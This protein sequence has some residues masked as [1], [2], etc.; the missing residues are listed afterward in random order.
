M[1]EQVLLVDDD[2]NIRRT[3]TMGLEDNGWEVMSCATGEEA[4][5]RFAESAVDVV[6]LDI[7]LPGID[8]FEVCRRIRGQVGAERSGLDALIV[9][10]TARHESDREKLAHE[11]GGDDYIRKPFKPSELSARMSALLQRPNRPTT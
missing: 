2:P 7:G 3:L 5:E 8:G 4:V 10:M 11:A 9:F 1:G 6:V